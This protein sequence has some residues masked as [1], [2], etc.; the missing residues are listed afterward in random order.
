MHTF[1]NRRDRVV[2]IPPD[3]KLLGRKLKMKFYI[4][5]GKDMYFEGQVCSYD[6]Q[7]G[8]Y[9][10]FFPSDGTTWYIFADEEDVMLL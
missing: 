1:F 7:T 4:E 9:G 3:L 2:Y 6:E 8:K 10:V 5:E